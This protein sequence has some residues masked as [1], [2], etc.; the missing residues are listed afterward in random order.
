VVAAA[1]RGG[2]AAPVNEQ[3]VDLV[4]EVEQSGAFLTPA[5]VVARVRL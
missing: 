5:E 3:I 2:V 1:K 4:H